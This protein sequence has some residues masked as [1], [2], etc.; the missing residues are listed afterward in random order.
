MEAFPLNFWSKFLIDKDLLICTEFI[1][2]F[3]LIIFFTAIF[4]HNA[5]ISAH[6]IFSFI[7][8]FRLNYCAFLHLLLVLATIFFISPLRLL[9]FYIFQKTRY[10]LEASIWISW[11]ILIFHLAF[12]FSITFLSHFI[13]FSSGIHYEAII[14]ISC[15]ILIFSQVWFLMIISF[16]SPFFSF[17]A[18]FFF[19][20][21]FANLSYFW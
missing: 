10:N 6:H 15:F 18:F 5:F 19:S 11:G 12:S 13:L 2:L 3:I 14:S 20:A 4:L 7:P 1:Q 9:S 8:S 21:I 17:S 16:D